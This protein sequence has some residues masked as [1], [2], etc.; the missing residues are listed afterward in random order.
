MTD[1]MK[2]SAKYDMSVI[3]QLP[4]LPVVKGMQPLQISSCLT[5]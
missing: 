5:D 3:G 4:M 1:Y 2:R